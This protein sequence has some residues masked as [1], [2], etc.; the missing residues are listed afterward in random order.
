MK[1]SCRTIH[2]KDSTLQG[3]T[4]EREKERTKVIMD[5]LS[6]KLENLSGTSLY[7]VVPSFLLQIRKAISFLRREMGVGIVV[8]KLLLLL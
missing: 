8:E 4:R 6:L 3:H 1:C 2:S 5:K 7:L